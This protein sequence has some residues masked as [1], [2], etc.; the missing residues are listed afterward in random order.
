VK[1]SV[2]KELMDLPGN[3]PAVLEEDLRNLR[4]INRYL[5][6]YR[7]I[8]KGLEEIVDG[9][10]SREI[11]ILDVGT[12]SADIPVALVRWARTRDIGI[13]IV[14]L[15]PDPVTA[16]I[17]AS[18]TRHLGEISVVRGDASE[19]PFPPASF[20][21]VLAS[22]LLHHFPEERIIA[23]LKTWSQLARRA[24]VVGDLVRHPIAY[25]G[26]HWLTWLCT[27]NPMTLTDA[28]LSVKRAFTVREW[29]ELFRRAAVGN[30]QILS[31]FPYRIMAR[32]HLAG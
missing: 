26:I 4:L 22:Q 17:A 18:R 23:L 7:C 30:F 19:P 32:V 24:I 1:R 21:C 16:C 20:D 9:K 13:R 11:S 12:G 8:R 15:E 10:Q 14:A 25:Y 6:G 28:P 31:V 3:A 27:R 5:G 2:E 29:R